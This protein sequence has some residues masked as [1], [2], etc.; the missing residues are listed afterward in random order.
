[1]ATKNERTSA[2]QGN[3]H[4][5][6]ASQGKKNRRTLDERIAT[7][8]TAIRNLAGDVYAEEGPDGRAAILPSASKELDIKLK[9]HRQPSLPLVG[10]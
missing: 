9:A 2:P 3:T 5:S 1:M 8:L 7:S 6:S 10:K 4:V